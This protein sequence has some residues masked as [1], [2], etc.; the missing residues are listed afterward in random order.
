MSEHREL[1]ARQKAFCHNV[2]QGM[3][4]REAYRKAYDININNIED[5]DANASLLLNNHK[6]KEY[7]ASYE[8]PLLNKLGITAEYILNGLKTIADKPDAKDSDK[9][10]AL[11]IL[12]KHK[13]LLL[14]A[15]R[16]ISE[17]TVKNNEDDPFVIAINKAKE[18]KKQ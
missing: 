1:N 4:Q 7:I 13:D 17:V 3:T 11:E 18:R 16:Q 5:C 9:A 15:E 6:V 8:Q 2:I 14:F 10:K 12:A